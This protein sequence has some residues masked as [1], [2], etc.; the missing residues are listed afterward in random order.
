MMITFVLALGDGTSN[1][2]A[3]LP[4]SWSRTFAA[5][6]ARPQAASL[7]WPPLT[8]RKLRFALQAPLVSYAGSMTRATPRRGPYSQ[9]EL[10]PRSPVAPNRSP[11]L[12]N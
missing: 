3:E 10:P 12:R 5:A 7:P 1:V 8:R 11:V 4:V 6:I 9:A 2:G